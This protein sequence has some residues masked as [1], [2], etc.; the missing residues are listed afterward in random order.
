MVGALV[1][2]SVNVATFEVALP[3]VLLTV[4]VYEP[5]L[6]ACT[7][8][9][10]SVALLVPTASA[11]L[12]AKGSEPGAPAAAPAVGAAPDTGSAAPATAGPAPHAPA[13][14]TP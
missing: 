3:W 4:Q 7:L 9:S 14:S 11:E 6:A 5:A 1:A 13:A 2:L 12:S 8:V 10:V